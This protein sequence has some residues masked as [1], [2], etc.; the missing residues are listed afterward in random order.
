[1]TVNY[2][3]CIEKSLKKSQDY[4][5]YLKNLVVSLL[6]KTGNLRSRRNQGKEDH[7]FPHTPAELFSHKLLIKPRHY[8]I[9]SLPPPAH[10]KMVTSSLPQM[11]ITANAA[12]RC[13]SG[14]EVS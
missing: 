6:R 5:E 2:E 14:W 1:M 13:R 3:K 8:R 12:C 11:A 9:V 7:P 4:S 10:K